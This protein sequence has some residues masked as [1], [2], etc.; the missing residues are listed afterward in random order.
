MNG[1]NERTTM[2]LGPNASPTIDPNVVRMPAVV[3][4]DGCFVDSICVLS[5]A[6]APLF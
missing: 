5:P 6:P 2:A 1:P 4:S 3:A